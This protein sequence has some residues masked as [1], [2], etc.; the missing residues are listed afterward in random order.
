MAKRTKK[1]EPAKRASQSSDAVQMLKADHKQIRKLFDQFRGAP[2]HEKDPIAARLFAD[3]EI[4]AKLEEELFYPAVQAKLE[5]HGFET[6][7]QG[8]GLDLAD[9]EEQEEILETGQMEIDGM[10]LQGDEDDEE[11]EETEAEEMITAAYESHQAM[12]DLIQQLRTLDPESE[13]FGELFSQ[14]EE[15]VLEHVAEEE[16]AILPLAA[17]ELDIQA[18]GLEMQRRKNDLLSQSSQAA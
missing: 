3:L 14:L 12:K 5:P 4:H 9:G 6:T 7:S 16:S 11:S 18:L 8:N 17:S 2:D 10:E 15:A 13:D 1:S